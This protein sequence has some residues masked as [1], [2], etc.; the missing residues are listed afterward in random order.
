M[1]LL[2]TVWDIQ[3]MFKN[4]ENCLKLPRTVWNFWELFETSKRC[5][6]IPKTVWDFWELFKT[7]KN[8]LR[9][10]RTVWKFPKT[11]WHFRELCQILRTLHKRPSL[12]K[13]P[14]FLFPNVLKRWSFQKKWTGI[15]SFLY[16]QE[17]WY[18]FSPKIWYYS[19]G[20]KWKMVFLKKNTWKYDI[21]F[22]CSK[23]MVFPKNLCWN[24]IS[25]IMRKDPISFSQKCDIFFTDRKWKMIFLKKY[26]EIWCFL[27]VGKDGVSFSYKYQITLLSKKQRWSFPK[28]TPNDDIS[29]I[30]EKDDIYPKKDNIGI[31]CTF[32]ETFLSVFIYCFP[33]KKTGNLIYRVEIW[34]YL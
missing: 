33:I 4:P 34:L 3:K 15:W 22:K 8:C 24:M 7:S 31:L 17:R 25:Y 14:Y 9:L 20:R 13:K 26:M 28:N 5:L 10:L 29:G 18:F 16:H 6:K 30:T 11:V 21:F 1:R 19:L 2:R 23:K 12:L 27:Y 32:M